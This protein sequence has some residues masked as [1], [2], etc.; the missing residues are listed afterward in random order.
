MSKA[1]DFILKAVGAVIFWVLF[2][3]V[4]WP[5][6]G[7]FVPD[8]LWL[9]IREIRVS[10]G[11]L[12]VAIDRKVGSLPFDD[13]VLLDR[14]GTPCIDKDGRKKP[15]ECIE[16]PFYIA[17]AEIN[18]RRVLG[19]QEVPS[20]CPGGRYGLTF[21]KGM[22]YP[23][24]GRNI[25]W[26]LDSPPNAGCNLGNGGYAADFTWRRTWMGLKLEA[27]GTSNVFFVGPIPQGAMPPAPPAPPPPWGHFPS[28]PQ[29]PPSPPAPQ[30]GSEVPTKL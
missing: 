10:S 7:W 9:D 27:T 2:T 1:S 5:H 30:W 18:I 24:Q 25:D 19:A 21:F 15:G 23:A 6:L 26:Y 28:V 16:T 13:T 29:F 14:N 4:V 22:P 17:D 11:V 12:G 20:S 3:T 8:R